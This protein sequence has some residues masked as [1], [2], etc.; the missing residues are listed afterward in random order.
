MLRL[1]AIPSRAGQPGWTDVVRDAT[2]I[3][4]AALSDL[5]SLLRL[6][7]WAGLGVA[8]ATVFMLAMAH[9]AGR[10]A[11]LRTHR[12]VGAP[13]RTLRLYL[14]IEGS[15]LS[16]G[17]LT[18]GVTIGYAALQ[19][20]LSAWPETAGI[21]RFVPGTVGLLIAASVVTVGAL[22]SLGLA[23]RRRQLQAGDGLVSLK[24]PTIQIGVS[25][26]ALT[27][28]AIVL[29]RAGALAAL[30]AGPLELRGTI[31]QIDSG[32][33]SPSARAS[34]Y[35]ELLQR[36]GPEW[37]TDVSLA[38]PGYHLGLG[39]ADYVR[40][41]C[42]NCVWSG[43]MVRWHNFD[44]V[45]HFVSPDSFAARG[46]SL[47]TGRLFTLADTWTAERVAVV[48]R[49]LAG[50]HFESGD[51]VGRRIFF[52]GA[53]L[54]TG[55]RV[56][57]IVQDE[58]SSALGG[59]K[60]P[61]EAAYLSAL[62]H[63]PIVTELHVGSVGA[64]AL[65]SLLASIRDVLGPQVEIQSATDAREHVSR[66]SRPLAWLG[67]WFAVVGAMALGIGIIGTALTMLMW[68][69]SHSSELALRRAVGATRLRITTM[70]LFQALRVA[71]GGVLLGAAGFV[72]V[73]WT[74]LSTV[75]TDLPVW[76]PGLIAILA[77]PL[78]VSVVTSALV[79]AQPVT[80]APPSSFLR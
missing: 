3:Q 36:L 46:T 29:E 10:G 15:V 40:T 71:A 49:H 16:L 70:V 37:G 5:L 77:V 22:L 66:A 34:R 21:A 30:G 23:G 41:E 76:D 6:V 59:A 75:I 31:L 56:I 13:M 51:A 39:T 14:L 7:A 73:L 53:I 60:Q 44:A 4:G 74:P 78:A 48:N 63:P 9:A 80:A 11:E 2:D 20:S 28:A 64:Q 57:G 1:P 33:A 42:G 50:Q 67:I 43:I 47:V 26:A 72:V 62:Q 68:V 52:G 54:G 69:R 12:A 19:V 18:L 27:A 17:L 8:L 38:G 79:A 55:Y 35:G 24:V 32:I 25:L 65:A 58:P 61:R 45:H